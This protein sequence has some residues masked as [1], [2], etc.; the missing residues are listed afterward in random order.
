M[1]LEPHLRRNLE[2]TYYE[3]GH[4]MYTARPALE[5]LH[6]DLSKFYDETVNGG[7]R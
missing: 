3:G 5:Q 4:M 7:L 2:F 6:V 1:M